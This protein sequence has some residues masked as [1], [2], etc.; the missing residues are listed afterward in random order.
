ML[1]IAIST[2][3]QYTLYTNYINVLIIVLYDPYMNDTLINKKHKLSTYYH[4]GCKKT[5][6]SKDLRKQM[7]FCIPGQA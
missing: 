4:L 3:M 2:L 7:L 5:S 6:S 1:D